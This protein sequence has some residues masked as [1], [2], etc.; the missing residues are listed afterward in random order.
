[1]GID[2]GS[3]TITVAELKGG[4]GRPAITNFGGLEL[5]PDSVREGEILDVPSVAAAVR[6][7]MGTAGIKM[8]KVWL[9]VANQRVVVRQVD[10]PWVEEKELKASLRYQVQDFIPIPVEEAELD[11]HIV[12]EYVNDEGER[13]R[14]M[15]LVAAHRD[16]VNAHVEVAKQA[17][18]KPIGID[19]NSF[20]VLR[21]LGS[22]SSMEP[23]DEVLVDIGAD[24]TNIVVHRAGQPTFVR[25]L[26]MG[27]DDITDALESGLSVSREEAEAAKRGVVVGS[28]GDVTS[29]I[30]T[31]RADNFIDEI[32]SSLDYFQAQTGEVNLASVVLSGGGA[33]LQGLDERLAIALRLPVETGNPFPRLEV[34]NSV[35][36][37][38][39]LAKVGPSMTTAVG[40]AMGGLE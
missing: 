17:G 3:R 9:G 37:E 5:P 20:A 34:K 27:G 14:R 7:L 21:S 40:L 39:D 38:D 28:E 32:R 33:S 8:K 35:Y 6:E 12:D 26:V 31:E 22:T 11:V 23:G 16:T 18:L 29:R 13:F 25:I 10:L 30:V 2:I 15:L 36:G 24:V 19:L 1:M 4:R